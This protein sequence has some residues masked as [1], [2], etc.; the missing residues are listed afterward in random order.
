MPW[1]AALETVALTADWQSQGQGPCAGGEW[2]EL[3]G[4]SHTLSSPHASWGPPPN[5]GGSAGH[6]LSA[7]SQPPCP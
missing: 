4:V 1:L 2:G 7:L 3:K 5:P 6:S